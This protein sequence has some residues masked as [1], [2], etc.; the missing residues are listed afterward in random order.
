MKFCIVGRLQLDQGEI[1]LLQA[2]KVVTTPTPRR[3]PPGATSALSFL[4]HFRCIY[5]NVNVLCSCI[6]GC[7]LIRFVEQKFCIHLLLFRRISGL[8]NIPLIL[9]MSIFAE[10]GGRIHE[11]FYYVLSPNFFCVLPPVRYSHI[12]QTDTIQIELC[13]ML[14]RQTDLFCIDCV[15]YV[16]TLNERNGGLLSNVRI[17]W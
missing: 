10:L 3:F 2:M 6:A 14:R 9:R 11:D 17:D 4:I 15:W 16:V 7:I 1:I 5:Y 13:T 12:N 8:L